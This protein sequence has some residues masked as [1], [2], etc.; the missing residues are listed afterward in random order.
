VTEVDPLT[1]IIVASIA[2]AGPTLGI[3]ANGWI[4]GR[5][6]KQGWERDDIVAAKLL[7]SNERVAKATARASVL[8]ERVERKVDE[9]K[10][11]VDGAHTEDLI[12]QAAAL[13]QLIELM[14][15]ALDRPGVDDPAAVARRDVAVEELRR[16]H[17]VLGERAAAASLATRQLVVAEKMVAAI[18]E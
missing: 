5:R 7:E 3:I 14:N 17:R 10:H 1:L 8:A 12:A 2:S 4:T 18:P 15:V 6:Q 16:Q 9:V 13:S 11:L